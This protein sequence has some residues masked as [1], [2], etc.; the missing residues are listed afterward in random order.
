MSLSNQTRNVAQTSPAAS[1]RSSTSLETMPIKRARAKAKA[2]K[3]TKAAISP[4]TGILKCSNPPRKLRK[5]PSPIQPPRPLAMGQS[6]GIG[7][8]ERTPADK[9]TQP[10]KT[11][12]RRARSQKRRGGRGFNIR[13]TPENS[14]NPPSTKAALPISCMS[15]LARDAPGAPSLLEIRPSP[16]VS[17]VESNGLKLSIE[18]SINAPRPQSKSAVTAR[19]NVDAAGTFKS[20]I[21][22]W[23]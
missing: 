3:I 12:P 19:R 8:A 15:M 20:S 18:R 5:K 13:R 23:A 16:P 22:L 14:V 9:T 10:I 2:A 17:A 6:W 7:K 11:A 4:D 1:Q 21:K